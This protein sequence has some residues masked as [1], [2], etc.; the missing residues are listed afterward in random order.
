MVLVSSV[1][2]FEQW[3]LAPNAPP[4]LLARSIED[5]PGRL[6]LL[7]HCPQLGLAMCNH[8][9]RLELNADDFLW[10][11]NGVYAVV[12][13]AE[14]ARLRAEG[15]S[16]FVAAALEHPWMQT[17]AYLRSAGYQLGLFTLGEFRVPSRAMLNNGQMTLYPW[18]PDAVDEKPPDR[19]PWKGPL[20]VWEYFVV[21]L[22]LVACGA[23]WVRGELDRKQRAI[24][25]L[26]VAAVLINALVVVAS[27]PAPRYGARVIWLVPMAA[28][29]AVCGRNPAAAI[30][31]TDL[32]E[33]I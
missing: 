23:L 28:L 32:R 14:A 1:I 31:A 18:V 16:M 9:D 24:L 11:R 5:G 15:N 10:H 3:S 19:A 27:M 12:S 6:Y 8:L 30:G 13:R 4:Y 25:L 22:S 17:R 26:V 29:I 2:G 7:A 33:R 20:N 21:A